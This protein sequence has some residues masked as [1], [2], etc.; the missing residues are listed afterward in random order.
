METTTKWPA[1][2]AGMSWSGLSPT[3]RRAG[4]ILLRDTLGIASAGTRATGL[5][6]TLD[7]LRAL[8]SG[9]VAV[10][11]TD[12]RLPPA[13]AGLA[14]SALVHAWDFDDTHDDAVVH[15]MAVAL[16]AALAAGTHAGRSGADI[17]DG[18]VVGVQVLSRLS[19]ALGAR[20]GMVRT[21][22]LGS[23]AAAAAAA[24][25]LGLG[26]E[27]IGNAMALALPAAGSPHSRQVVEDSAVNKRLQ[28]GLAVQAGL[29]AAAFARA[30]V[31]GPAGWA[32]GTYGLLAGVDDAASTLFAPGWEGA[33]LS[34]KPYPACRYTHAAITA[35]AEASTGIASERISSVDVHVPDGAAYLLVSRPFERRGRPVI[36]AQFSIPWLVA[37]QLV[38][39]AVDLTTIA[40]P[41]LLDA[42]VE[43]F[44]A[45]VTVHQ[46]AEGTATMAPATVVLRTDDGQRHEA[47]SPMTGSPEHPLT[48]AQLAAKTAACAQV[49]GH[50]PGATVADIAALAE[51]FAD[52]S[53]AEV[54]PAL[55]ALGS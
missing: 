33:E 14:L 17:L 2:L 16:P 55:A 31:E 28:P 36:D 48:E 49:G 50:E 27:G 34:L 11:W 13:Q 32:D 9:D 29:T 8:G 10:P 5:E 1:E 4:T 18:V 38:T 53:P 54:G 22:G 20:H 3:E 30:G 15:T 47:T 45:R 24:R 12:L 21:A 25:T 35:A 42:H 44:A 43:A 6:P 39:G 37:A 52:L 51:R 7:A 40:G 19:L 41:T 26:L 23:V 46:D